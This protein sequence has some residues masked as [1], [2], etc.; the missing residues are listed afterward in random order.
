MYPHTFRS[1]AARSTAAKWRRGCL[2]VCITAATFLLAVGSSPMAADA[3]N[4]QWQQGAAQMSQPVRITKRPTATNS[5]GFVAPR[6]KAVAKQAAFVEPVAEQNR[7]A[8]RRQPRVA[9][10]S[11]AK[12][13]KRAQSA[14]RIPVTSGGDVNFASAVKR[15][16]AQLEHAE[17]I[18][19]PP[20]ACVCGDGPCSCGFDPG[21]GL[22]EPG[23]GCVEP[24]C[25]CPVFAGGPPVCADPVCG[26][27]VYGDCS[28]GDIACCGDCVGGC[29]P[30]SLGGCKERG[31]IPICIY[32]PPIKEITLFGGVQGFK[33]PLDYNPAQRDAG[34]FGFHQGV[35]IGGRMSWLPWHGLGYQIGYRGT[36]NQLSGDVPTGS[37]S[38]SQQFFTTGLYQRAPVGWQWGVVYD[39]LQ[40]ERQVSTNFSQVRGLISFTNTVGGEVGFEF[41]AGTSEQTIGAFTF[42][43]ADQYRLFWRHHG[44]TGGE[45]R[46]FIGGSGDSQVILGAD[47][48]APL[49]HRWSIQT[50]FTYF[51]PTDGGNGLAGGA[52]AASPNATEEAWN[53]GISLIWHYGARGK[54]WYR[55]PWRPLFDVADNGSL[56]VDDID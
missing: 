39:L 17:A 21:C 55:S 45:F 6:K 42:E 56:V 31:A 32:L 36:Q 41:A 46:S 28:C 1:D 37:D 9:K 20:E 16:N 7:S 38:H 33:G 23:C 27:G 40:D 49:N 44:R 52:A 11:S 51:I 30:P 26:D 53:L 24:N 8:T 25:G 12:Q 47:L 48:T 19:V 10:A 34:N 15:A 50:G 43:P 2:G 29:C 4:L 18:G 35:N 54:E 3:Q 13:Q 14:S 5:Q 22:P